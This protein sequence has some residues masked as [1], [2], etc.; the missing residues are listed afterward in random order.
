MNT[1]SFILFFLF[2]VSGNIF[3]QKKQSLPQIYAA[4]PVTVVQ[5]FK[6]DSLNLKG[7]KFSAKDMLKM[8]LSIPEQEA[9]VRPLKADTAGY[10]F[11]EKPTEKN[12]IMQLFTFNVSADRY[13]KGTLKITSPGMMEIYVDGKLVATKATEEKTFR[14]DK[15]S[16]TASLTPYPQQSRVVIKMIVTGKD[17]S[18]TTLKEDVPPTFKVEIE[19]EK[20]DSLT[21]FSFSNT[22]KRFVNF[23]DMMLGKRVTNIR[24]SPEG[25]YALIFYWNT[26]GDKGTSTTELYNIKAKSTVLID[27]DGAKKQ[28]NWMPES[29]KLF[30]ISKT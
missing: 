27:T 25:E 24:V 10:F 16:V 9:F 11:P 14:S 6:V 4:P 5:P 3:S 12:T 26:F 1:K 19:N 30:Y 18:I 29:E 20:N 28:L 13:A 23:T 17:E 2:I 21:V 7:E 15:K 8:S 22:D